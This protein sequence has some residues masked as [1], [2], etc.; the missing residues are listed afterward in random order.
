M[1]KRGCLSKLAPILFKTM[2][3][4]VYVLGRGSVFDNLELR[5]S[6]RSIEKYLTN[7]RT[8]YVVGE[9]PAWL[10]GVVHLP[11]PDKY[12]C[13]ER[14]IKEKIEVACYYPPVSEKFLHVH[15][16]HFCLMRQDAAKV[17]YYAGST[18]TQLARNTKTKNNYITSVMNTIDALRLHKLPELNFDIHTPIIYDKRL[19]VAT[20]S[21]YSWDK[22]GG[23]VVKSLYGN[24]LGLSPVNLP[25]VKIRHDMPLY[26]IV[27]QLRGRP[28][29]SV[30][31]RGLTEKMRALLQELYPEKSRFEL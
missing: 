6:L 22:R 30:G 8:V 19:F 25:D 5:Y 3:D 23:Y 27:E 13:K 16:D 31:D 24:T 12:R 17:P 15:D 21:L 1:K 14:N 20:M 11:Y 2:I 26:A 7:F 4:I 29:W 10:T 18:L 9:R 28:W